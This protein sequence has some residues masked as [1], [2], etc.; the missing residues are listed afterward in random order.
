M[1]VAMPQLG[2]MEKLESSITV[3][4]L[5][6]MNSALSPMKVKVRFPKFTMTRDYSLSST[7]KDMGMGIAF[8]GYADFSGISPGIQTRIENVFHKAYI[9]VHEEGTEAA[10]ATGVGVGVTSAPLV[11]EFAADRP[12]LFFLMEESTGAILFMGKMAD[13]GK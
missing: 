5:E 8:G 4:T 11:Q 1:L 10:G 12:F 6:R 13:P 7:L 3:Q 2:G 9:D